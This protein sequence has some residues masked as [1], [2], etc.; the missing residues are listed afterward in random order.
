MSLLLQ[1]CSNYSKR[2]APFTST[3]FFFFINYDLTPNIQITR[4]I[5]W[6]RI[7]P[8]LWIRKWIHIRL[9][10]QKKKKSNKQ[11]NEKEKLLPPKKKMKNKALLY[12]LA[13]I[14]A[15]IFP[16]QFRMGLAVW[17]CERKY[18]YQIE[19][20]SRLWWVLLTFELLRCYSIKLCHL[21]REGQAAEVK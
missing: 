14:C 18:I 13:K 15:A 20:T 1:I 16:Y 9:T 17:L 12:T 21:L 19:G 3:L 7:H 8:F 10:N 4:F 11:T 6:T 2:R 5:N